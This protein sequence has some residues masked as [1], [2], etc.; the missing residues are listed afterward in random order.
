M[1]T[2]VAYTKNGDRIQHIGDYTTKEECIERLIAEARESMNDCDSIEDCRYGLE[3]RG[4]Y[5]LGYSCMYVYFKE[6]EV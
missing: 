1:K 4:Y 3:M 6:V 2:F 5:L